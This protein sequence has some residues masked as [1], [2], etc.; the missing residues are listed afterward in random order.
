MAILRWSEDGICHGKFRHLNV[1]VMM[2]AE[3]SFGVQS[4]DGGREGMG[5]EWYPDVWLRLGC[6]YGPNEIPTHS[7]PAGEGKGEG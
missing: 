4:R 6:C 7:P 2:A 5:W 3:S 1:T